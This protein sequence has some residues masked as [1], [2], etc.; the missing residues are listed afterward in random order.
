MS[1]LNYQQVAQLAYNAGWRGKDAQTAVAIVPA[2]SSFETMK[3]NFAG[4]DYSFGLWQINM[5][6]QMGADRR[7]K[8]GLSSNEQL[9]DPATNA[10]VAHAIYTEAGNKFTD[11]STY[12][13][14]KFTLYLNGAVFAVKQ[15][16]QGKTGI[17]IPTYDPGKIP[18]EGSWGATSLNPLSG[19]DQV[20]KAVSDIGGFITNKENWFRAASIGGGGILIIVAVSLVVGELGLETII[21]KVIPKGALRSVKGAPAKATVVGGAARV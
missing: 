3:T 4:R 9:F 11:W 6:G 17:Q 2:E 1:R 10:R 19:I 7:A 16:E 20:G 18:A 12:N 8:Y 21:K 14:G 5:K 13:D 15:I